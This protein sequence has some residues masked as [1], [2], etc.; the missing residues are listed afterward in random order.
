MLLL[1]STSDKIQ[2]TGTSAVLPT[3]SGQVAVT[4]TQDA[5]NKFLKF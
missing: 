4:V 2:I 3:A 5:T 1:T